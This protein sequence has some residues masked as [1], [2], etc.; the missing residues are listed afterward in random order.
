[1]VA[2]DIHAVVKVGVGPQGE[3]I[4][5]GLSLRMQR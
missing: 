3:V 4:D 1:W 5:T 2:Q